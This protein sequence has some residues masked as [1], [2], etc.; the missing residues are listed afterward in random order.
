MYEPQNDQNGEPE[1]RD[2][3][4]SNDEYSRRIID[5]SVL[6]DGRQDPDRNRNE[7]SQHQA[8]DGQI[9]RHGI[10]ALEF[11]NDGLARPVGVPKVQPHRAPEPLPILHNQGLIESEFLPDLLQGLLVRLTAFARA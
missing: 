11:L 1:I 7:R 8:H 6:P 5:Q 4:A 3:Q 10:A 2:R 9:C